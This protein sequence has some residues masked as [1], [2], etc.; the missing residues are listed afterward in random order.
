MPGR[1]SADVRRSLQAARKAAIHLGHKSVL[2]EHLLLGFLEQPGSVRDACQAVGVTPSNVEQ[3]VHGALAERKRGR[4]S[5]RLP[6]HKVFEFAEY[7]SKM[8]EHN[9]IGA[10]HLM[11]AILR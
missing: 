11:L 7:E 2:V 1:Y 8:L 5:P 6:S 3:A 4:R 9:A 10:V